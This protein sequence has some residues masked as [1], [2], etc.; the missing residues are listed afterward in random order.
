MGIH[1]SISSFDLFKIGIGPP[2]SHTVGTMRAAFIFIKVE[3][4][5][6]LGATGIGHD[7]HKAILLGLEG[8][9]SE[10]VNTDLTTDRV[11]EIS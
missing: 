8:E 1:L 11:N 4:F 10:T 5:G 9:L 6:S 7:N 2:S 3:F